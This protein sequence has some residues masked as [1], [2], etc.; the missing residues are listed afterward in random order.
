[1]RESA[2]PV[3][4]QVAGRQRRT[5]VV[6]GGGTGIGAAVAAALVSDG[7]EVLLLGRRADRLDATAALLRAAT[8]DASVHTVTADLTDPGEAAKAA[9]AARDLLGHVDVVVANAGSPAPATGSDLESL[10]ASWLTAFGANTLTAVL[11]TSALDPLLTSPGGRVVVVG[12]AAAARGNSTPSY[13]AAKGA[14]EAWVRALANA[15][16]PRGITANVVAPGYT[17]GTELV[18]GRIS[19]DRH[20]RLVAGTSLGRAATTDEI[21]AV[22]TFLSSTA[23]SYVTGQSVTV[24]GGLR[25]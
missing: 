7:V 5:A 6:S 1:M 15:Y 22:V 21:A 12:S 11:L 23:A 3:S 18:A 8:P 14:L 19:P 2:T 4:E 16:G 9:D 25:V 10:A 24:D 17:S 13:V 20:E